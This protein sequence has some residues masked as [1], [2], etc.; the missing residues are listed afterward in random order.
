MRIGAALLIFTVLQSVVT[1]EADETVFVSGPTRTHLLELFTSEGCSSCPPAEA[2]LSRLKDNK[3]L[4]RDF[5]PIAFHVD[6]WDRL[7]WRDRFASPQWT[8]RQQIL[9]ARWNAGS[10]YTPAFVLDGSES[11]AS[12][13]RASSENGGTL[14]VRCAGDEVRVSFASTR[15]NAGSFEA[16]LAG[17][18]FD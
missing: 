9:A 10:V 2:W 11:S 6:Y 3:Q 18:G 5:V 16:H 12:V 15:T 8:Q 4:W 17:L 7:G 14:R 13:P 1:A